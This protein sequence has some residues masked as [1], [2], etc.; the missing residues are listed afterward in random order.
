MHEKAVG[1]GWPA[2]NAGLEI[3]SVIKASGNCDV[4]AGGP[5]HEARADASNKTVSLFIEAA[6]K[7]LRES[8]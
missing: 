8:D 1:M 4:C 3:E 2:A 7:N 6:S 5:P